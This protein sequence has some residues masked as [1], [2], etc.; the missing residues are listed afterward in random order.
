MKKILLPVLATALMFAASCKKPANNNL[1]TS[2]WSFKSDTYTGDSCELYNGFFEVWP[3]GNGGDENFI[4]ISFPNNTLPSA[5]TYNVVNSNRF[6]SSTL[7]NVALVGF[8]SRGNTYTSTGIGTNQ[9]LTVTV[10]APGK[11]QVTGTG[12]EMKDGLNDSS[13]ITLKMIQ[14][15]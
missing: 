13:A 8:T 3:N 15:F 5:G 4:F 9:T 11:V 14:T 1:A 10:Y 7:N 12:I 6:G 2:T